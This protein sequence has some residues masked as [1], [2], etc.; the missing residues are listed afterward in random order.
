[1]KKYESE[2]RDKEKLLENLTFHA[3]IRCDNYSKKNN[4]NIR[5]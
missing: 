4:E 1:M 3:D 5:W 2:I